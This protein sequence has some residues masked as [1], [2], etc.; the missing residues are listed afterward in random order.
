MARSVSSH[1]FRSGRFSEVLV[2]LPRASGI[3]WAGMAQPSGTQ[4]AQAQKSDDDGDTGKL[5]LLGLLTLRSRRASPAGPRRLRPLRGGDDGTGRGPFRDHQGVP[6]G[7][8]AR[9]Q[10]SRHRCRGPTD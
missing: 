8:R 5:R 2:A 3:G 1:D 4:A 9:P 10:T 7:I 6:L